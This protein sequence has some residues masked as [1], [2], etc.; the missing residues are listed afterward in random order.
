MRT[1]A[2]H[3]FL[4]LLL[5]TQIIDLGFAKKVVDKTYT[6]CGTPE[7][8]APEIIMS[9]GHDKAADYWS[10]GVLV[11]ELFVGVTP[12]YRPHSTQL[13]MFKR[14]AT[15]KFTMPSY[16]DPQAAKLIRNGLLVRKPAERLGNLSRGYLDIKASD[17]FTK[18][19]ISWGAIMQKR[20]RAPWKPR[21]KNKFDSSHFDRMEEEHTRED[22]LTAEEQT[23][24]ASFA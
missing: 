24:F 13:E 6:L 22:P 23:Q 2:P 15:G 1:R 9:K 3:A 14:I 17:W 4:I 18:S 20:Q 10:Y 21:I 19:G 5:A 7:Y 16:I 11:Y 8:L 12:F